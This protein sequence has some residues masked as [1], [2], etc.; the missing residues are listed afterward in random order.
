MLRNALFVGGKD[1]KYL[2]RS[3][4]ALLW[5]FVMPI[6]FF[7]FIG[8]ITAGFGSGDGAG[9]ERIAMRAGDDAGFLLDQLVRRLEDRGYEVVRFDDA[10]A[11]AGGE[12]DETDDGAPSGGPD[13]FDDHA[14]RLSVPAGFTDRVLAGRPT[15]VRLA[16]R[17]SGLTTDYDTIR[18]GRAVYSL[19]ADLVVS[20]REGRPTPEAIDRLNAMPR[21][22]SL[23]V[24]P[25]GARRR[26]P[27]GFE[28]AVP[29][30]MVMFTLMNMV[31]S[32]AVLLVIERRQG[33]LRRLA[34]T[35][36]GRASVVYGKWSGKLA[37]GVVQ[38]AF[39]MLAGTVLFSMD[40]G[41]ELAM[42]VCVMLVYAAMMAAL[43]MVVGSL[44]RSEGQATGIGVVAANVLAALGGCWWPI[45]I[46][47]A[48]MQALQLFLPTG[49]AMDAMHKLISFGAGPASVL[50]HVIGMAAGTLVLLGAAARVFRYA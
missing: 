1:L 42:V 13:A 35:P 15:K 4:E 25:A 49:W 37:L 23:E 33:L 6:V 5:I 40:W 41:R 8:T 28:Q 50:P 14:R 45:E 10:E 29:G 20:A 11:A 22:L 16:L 47:P 3:R 36:I 34:S 32:G 24:T 12:A 48:W 26:I 7:Y 19:L 17:E 31:T 38:V 9:Q 44:A 27:T 30:I 18:V 46:T 39:A 43:G 21:A 2:L